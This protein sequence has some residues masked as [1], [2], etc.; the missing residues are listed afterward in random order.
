MRNTNMSNCT[1]KIQYSTKMQNGRHTSNKRSAG[2]ITV[3]N[4]NSNR[5]SQSY[6]NVDSTLQPPRIY[7][8]SC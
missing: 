3:L 7:N 1:N 8:T 5:S 6:I 2:S 4:L